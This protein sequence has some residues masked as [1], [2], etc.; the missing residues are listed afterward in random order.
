MIVS[1]KRM[2]ALRFTRD[3]LGKLAACARSADATKTGFLKFLINQY[4]DEHVLPELIEE[5]KKKG[6]AISQL[7]DEILENYRPNRFKGE[8]EDDEGTAAGRGHT[9]TPRKAK[10]GKH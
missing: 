3:E 10:P 7:L 1:Q 6:V 2:W 9:R 8:E 4:Y 5:A